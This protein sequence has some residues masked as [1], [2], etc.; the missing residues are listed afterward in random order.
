M[1]ILTEGDNPTD[2][3]HYEIVGGPGD[4]GIS[5]LGITVRKSIDISSV[6]LSQVLERPDAPLSWIWHKRGTPIEGHDPHDPS[7][8]V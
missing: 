1:P 8:F 4:S 2:G 5:S 3:R 6:H 7:T